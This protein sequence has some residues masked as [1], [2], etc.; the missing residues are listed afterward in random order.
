MSCTEVSKLCNNIVI[1]QDV[2][3]TDGN[4]V[5]NIPQDNY[6]NHH[7][8]CLIIAQDIPTET[9][10]AAPAVI[11]IGDATTPTYPL[12]K[13]DCSPVTACTLSNRTRYAVKVATSVAGGVFKVL[14]RLPMACAL[15]E[16][17]SLPLPVAE[18][19]GGTNG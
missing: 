2:A 12:V 11:T 3:F 5:I 6:E 9:T 4:L 15:A 18:A 13:C 7:K 8:Y 16:P 14:G 10:I 1:S 19:Q 17:E